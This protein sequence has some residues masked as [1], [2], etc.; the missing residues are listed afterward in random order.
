MHS[1][2]ALREIFLA[3]MQSQAFCKEPRNLYEPN[4][5]FLQI[6]G[7]RLRPVLLLMAT[8]LFDGNVQ[9]ALPA[10]LAIEY[11]HNFSL[12][13]DDVMDGAPLR[14]NFQTIHEKYNL[15]TAILSGDVL[16]VKAYEYLS[17]V[18]DQ[19]FRKVFEVYSKTAVEVCEG[20]QYDIDFETQ[21]EVT[22]AAYL[23]MIRLKTAVLLAASMKIG[24]I[25]GGAGEKDADLLYEYA[26]NLGVA[27]QIQDDILDA[28]GDE[29]LVGKQPGGD[30]IQNKKTLL[31]IEALLRSEAEDDRRLTEII[32]APVTDKAAKVAAVLDIF[33]TYNIRTFA[34]Q[35]RDSYV[36]KA[37]SALQQLSCAEEGKEALRQLVNHLVVREF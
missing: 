8:D 35:M 7:K 10:A 30:I 1:L 17:K 6:G 37:M 21:V 15:N 32:Q 3:Y 14:R 4:N 13:H 16:L 25:L 11:F 36:E 23:E 19:Y 28:F 29:S 33:E 34:L 24:A 31:L 27:F 22:H 26:E 2:E 9:A 12:I 5:Y 18:D 20:Q